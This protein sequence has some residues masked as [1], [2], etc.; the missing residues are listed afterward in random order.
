MID[1]HKKL[2]FTITDA[3]L[4]DRETMIALSHTIIRCAKIIGCT[5]DKLIEDL[6]AMY[7]LTTLVES[8]A[9]GGVQ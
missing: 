5:K 2:L 6:G 9:E 8:K 7:D 1:T 3:K 4:T